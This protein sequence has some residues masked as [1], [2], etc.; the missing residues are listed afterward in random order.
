MDWVWNPIPY[1]DDVK[2]Y[3]MVTI[4]I[5]KLIMLRMDTVVFRTIAV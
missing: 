4:L 5:F 3:G 2:R 1:N